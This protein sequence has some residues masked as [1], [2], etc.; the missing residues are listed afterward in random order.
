MERLKCATFTT[1]NMS[2]VRRQHAK[3]TQSKQQIEG[4][5]GEREKQSGSNKKN[6]SLK[7]NNDDDDEVEQKKIKIKNH[8]INYTQKFKSFLLEL[9]AMRQ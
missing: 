7:L 6:R 4:C 5:E 9:L 2:I 3:S 8:K 1:C